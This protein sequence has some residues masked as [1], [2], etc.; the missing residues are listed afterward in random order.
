MCTAQ[1]TG[2]LSDLRPLAEGEEMSELELDIRQAQ[3]ER[4]EE[5]ECPVF[6]EHQDLTYSE[7]D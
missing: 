3:L 1:G 5:R 4:S 7:S 6:E 2:D